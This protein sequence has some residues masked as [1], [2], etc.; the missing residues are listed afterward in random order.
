MSKNFFLK[1]N[2]TILVFIL[3]IVVLHVHAENNGIVKSSGQSNTMYINN[4]YQQIDF[5]SFEK[6]NPAVFEKAYQGFA[7]LKLAHKLNPEKEIISICDYSLS[8][9]TKRMWVI[10]L[11]EK[12]VLYNSFVAHGQGTGEEFATEFSNKE[13]SHQSSIGFYI[14]GNTY[15]GE[16]GLSLYLHG[17][18]EG[19]NSAAYERSI[20]L[21]GAAYVCE[22]FINQHKRL[23]RSWGCPAVSTSLAPQL[24]PL[25]KEGTC[26]FVYYP[27]TQYL[28]SSFWLNKKPNIRD[29]EHNGN[30]FEL[31]VPQ[32]P[33]EEETNPLVNR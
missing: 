27:S 11:H 15:I 4:L 18:D 16:H 14:T 23:G 10:D 6:L 25:L 24:I 31:K 1:F 7:N 13:N 32:Q 22:S 3:W 9:N 20:V 33:E 12:K 28:S 21:H 29:A 30:H 19:F 26:L 17:M 8:A 2:N 5:G